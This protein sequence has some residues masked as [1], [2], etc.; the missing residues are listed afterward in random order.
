M[1]DDRV[2][3]LANDPLLELM[4]QAL[5]VANN[6]LLDMMEEALILE[7]PAG[8]DSVVYGSLK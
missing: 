6:P 1:L 8:F 2:G 7:I 3:L 4:E 5:M